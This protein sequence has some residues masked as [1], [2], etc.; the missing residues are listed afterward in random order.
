MSEAPTLRAVDEEAPAEGQRRRRAPGGRKKAA[1]KTLLD[2][3]P[4]PWFIA[5]QAA[6]EG[7]LRPDSWGR[8]AVKHDPD[9]PEMFDVYRADPTIAADKHGL[10]W[11]IA[12]QQRWTRRYLLPLVRVFS[13]VVVALIV[14]T[15]RIC[16]IQWRWH[17]AIDWLCVWFIRRYCSPQVAYLLQRHFVVETNL[18]EFARINAGADDVEP[19]TLRPVT[20]PELGERTV[21]RHDFNM[22]NFIIG[23]GQSDQADVFDAVDL[24]K[25]D[26]SMLEIPAFDVEPKRFRWINID[27]LTSLYL[28]NI[29]FCFFLTERE[30]ERAVC[31][32]QLDESLMAMLANLTG[33][34]AFRGWT[35]MKFFPF[36][37]IPWDVPRLL[38]WHCVV[39]EYAHGRLVEAWAEQRALLD[40]TVDQKAEA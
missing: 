17:G 26:F 8:D 18:M 5:Q 22:Y 14:G 19:T 31:S 29:P 27:I 12:D 33:D 39:H 30:Y 35:P 11:L 37:Y 7:D 28:M 32:F 16:P 10:E 4:L 36:L 3:G 9:D 24:D 34:D 2:G 13:I 25:L 23:M 1:R 15:K 38:F 20:I 6:A 40:D 21:L